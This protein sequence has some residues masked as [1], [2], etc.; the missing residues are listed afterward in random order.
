MLS[1]DGLDQGIRE[2]GGKWAR[3][4]R[5]DEIAIRGI[6]GLTLFRRIYR[7]SHVNRRAKV[8]PILSIPQGALLRVRFHLLPVNSKRNF[9]PTLSCYGSIPR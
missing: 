7:S 1:K 6:G 3:W 9:L 8:V 4:A 5:F 2:R